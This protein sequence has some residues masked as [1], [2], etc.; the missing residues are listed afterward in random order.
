MAIARTTGRS[1]LWPFDGAI[2]GGS[3]DATTLTV[4][5][6]TKSGVAFVGPVCWADRGTHDIHSVSYMTG[7]IGSMGDGSTGSVARTSLQGVALAAGPP[8][9]PDGTI[10]GTGNGAYYSYA[11]GTGPASTTWTTDV[12]GADD[13][14]VAHGALRAVVFDLATVGSASALAYA[15]L[16]V[17]GGALMRAGSVQ[18]ISST[19]TSKAIVPNVILTAA[20][21]TIGWIDGTIPLASATI[22]EAYNSGTNPESRGNEFTVSGPTEIDGLWAQDSAAGSTR[23]FN[24]VLYAGASAVLTLGVDANAVRIS[25]GVD[26]VRAFTASPYTLVVGTTYRVMV[27]PTTTDSGSFSVLTL[28][29][30]GARSALCGTG[31]AY[32][33][34]HSTTFAS[35]TTT[36]VAC[37]GVMV[38]G[39]DNGASAGGGSVR[40]TGM[41]G[42]LSS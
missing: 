1:A 8:F 2:V 36:K 13:T 16:Q 11:K 27:E 28:G 18:N 41:N 23:D 7:T 14:S 33:T 5:V 30:A 29:A 20:D 22:A 26:I 19:W 34:K 38:C 6:A 25:A 4:D 21:G 9:Q 32:V 15:G 17:T 37:C 10:K 39:A 24:L 3:Y 31:V 40:Q 42:G 35:A 12:L